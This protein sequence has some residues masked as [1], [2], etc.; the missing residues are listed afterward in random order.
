[1]GEHNPN[2][3]FINPTSYT[4]IFTE[5]NKL[6]SKKANGPTSI[7]TNILKLMQPSIVQP[8]VE[9]INLSF[10]SGKYIDS[11]K[12]S[13]VIPIFKEKGSDLEY[14]NYRPIS[15]LSNI[16]K[17]IE[18]ILHE[19][20]FNFL[21]KYNCIYNLQFGFRKGHSTNHCLFDLTENIR[22]AIDENKYAVGVFVDLQKAFDTVDH[23]ILL[24][25]LF[26]Y[27][28]RG[29]A[30]NWFKSYL[31]D[32]QQFVYINGIESDI[33]KMEYGVPNLEN[34]LI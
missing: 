6:K 30:L 15:L 34:I 13:K 2:S 31:L 25:K 17:I 16:N 21:E 5:I 28:I 19:R 24:K 1:M 29:T 22:K 23:E 18:K 14:T 32:R 20:L 26:H 10:N 3:F 12:I 11:L 4:E 7:P 27:G 33:R 9:I 8:L